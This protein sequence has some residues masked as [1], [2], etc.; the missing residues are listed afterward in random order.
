MI[1]LN[2]ISKIYL[3]PGSTDMRLG[4]TGLRKKLLI[5]RS[6][7]VN[8]LYIFCGCSKNQIKILHIDYG[9][10]WLYQ[11]K[12]KKGKFIRPECGTE[13]E[14]T[15]RQLEILIEGLTFVSS[16]ESKGQELSFY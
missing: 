3:Y 4:I 8:T 5:S 10:I 11:N 6:L 7:E 13:T 2:D 1:D 16:I 15:R 14:I 12:L 9:S